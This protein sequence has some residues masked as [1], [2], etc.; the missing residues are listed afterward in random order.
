M[1]ICVFSITRKR[2]GQWTEPNYGKDI[3]AKRTD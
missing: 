2:S 1:K 3:D